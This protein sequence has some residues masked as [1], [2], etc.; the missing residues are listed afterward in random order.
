MAIDRDFKRERPNMDSRRFH[1]MNRAFEM[2]TR[3]FQEGDG[4]KRMRI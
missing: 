4:L 3:I 1:K 2:E